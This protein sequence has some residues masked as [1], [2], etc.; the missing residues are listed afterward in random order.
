MDDVFTCREPTLDGA[1]IFSLHLPH[2]QLSEFYE[3]SRHG[4]EHIACQFF[5]LLGT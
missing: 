1:D 5:L 4:K 3:V 2:A